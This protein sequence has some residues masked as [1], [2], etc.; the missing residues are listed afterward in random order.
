M[1]S[2]ELC[3]KESLELPHSNE[4]PNPGAGARP[5]VDA[6]VMKLMRKVYLRICGLK[7]GWLRQGLV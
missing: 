3:G 4:G 1:R 2:E 7:C 5:I 6:C